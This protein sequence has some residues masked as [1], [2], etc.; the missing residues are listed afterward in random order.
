M[1]RSNPDN[2]SLSHACIGIPWGAGQSVGVL[3]SKGRPRNRFLRASDSPTRVEAV[4]TSARTRDGVGARRSR[5]FAGTGFQL[6]MTE[7][8]SCSKWNIW[9]GRPY[10]GSSALTISF[11][12]TISLMPPGQIGFKLPNGRPLLPGGPPA[13]VRAFGTRRS[14][15]AST[16]LQIPSPAYGQRIHVPAGFLLSCAGQPQ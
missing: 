4:P 6:R 3:P 12:L 5:R 16:P 1:P 11:L 13:A 2:V 9:R 7:K 8:A 14:R 10:T 15:P